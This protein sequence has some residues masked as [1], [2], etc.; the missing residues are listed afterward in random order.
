MDYWPKGLPERKIWVYFG[1]VQ[2]KSKEMQIHMV[3]YVNGRT[4]WIFGPFPPCEPQK[5]L[6]SRST[7]AFKLDKDL[8]FL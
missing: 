8:G 3:N 5:N 1:E 7:V 2:S 4:M 6:E